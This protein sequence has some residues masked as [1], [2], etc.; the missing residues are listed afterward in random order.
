M[1]DSL[2]SVGQLWTNERT[3]CR[4]GNIRA[5]ELPPDQDGNRISLPF[6]RRGGLFEWHVLRR[7]SLN[8]P[9]RSLAIHSSRATS[10]IQ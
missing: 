3:D 7:C 10:H 9:G 8:P 4:F 5:L 6:I 1:R 2:L